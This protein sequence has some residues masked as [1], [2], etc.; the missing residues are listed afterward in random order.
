MRQFDGDAAGNGSALAGQQVDLAV[1]G[2]EK[3]EPRGARGGVM[4]QSQIMPMGQT[5]QTDFHGA[6]SWNCWAMR[7]TRRRAT[8]RLDISGQSSWPVAV[9]RWTWLRSPPITDSP[10][11]FAET[12]LAMIQS[13]C[14]RLRLDWA[15][16]SRLSVSAAKPI[17]RR[18]RFL[19]CPSVARM[20]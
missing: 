14:L 1:D 19:C 12:S 9:M 7:W 6:F 17:T 4:R 11:S 8:S 20:S 18:G 2:G 10:A 3:V 16:T 15:F 13:A 5:L